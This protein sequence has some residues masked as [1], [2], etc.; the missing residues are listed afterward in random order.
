[1]RLLWI[2]ACL[3]A[4]LA[5]QDPKAIVQRA[6][7]VYAQNEK[8]SRNY[9]YLERDDQRTLDGSGKVTKR[10]IRTWDITLLDGSPYRRLVAR[11]DKPL[12]PDEQRKEDEKLRKSNEQRRKETEE[13]RKR[14]IADWEAKRQKRYEDD[15]ELPEAFDFKMA[16]EERL[17]GVDVWVIAGAAHPRLAAASG[18][19]RA[20]TA[21]PNWRSKPWIPSRWDCSWCALPKAAGLSSSRRA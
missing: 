12:P 8:V 6:I 3:P 1:M 4:F 18:S 17:D 13:Q 9:T 2:A 14:R 21:W 20:I 11:D 15:R 16:G 5:A 10:E 19:P 7:E